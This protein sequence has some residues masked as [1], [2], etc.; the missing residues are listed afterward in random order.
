M[1]VRCR[2]TFH[3]A[4]ATSVA[5]G[6]SAQPPVINGGWSHQARVNVSSVLAIG[7]NVNSPSLLYTR[8]M[9][10]QRRESSPLESTEDTVGGPSSGELRGDR[11]KPAVDGCEFKSQLTPHS[12]PPRAASP[13]AL[14]CLGASNNRLRHVVLLQSEPR[15]SRCSFSVFVSFTHSP[16]ATSDPSCQ[17]VYAFKLQALGQ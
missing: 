11:M 4:L 9:A 13:L 14:S 7:F 8:G 5:D 10:H 6:C 15:L 3:L 12:A 1:L 17:V 2:R 16:S